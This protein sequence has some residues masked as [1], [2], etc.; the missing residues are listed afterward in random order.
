MIKFYAFFFE[1]AELLPNLLCTKTFLIL[2]L[3]KW[4][5]ILNPF[6]LICPTKHDLFV[7][8]KSKQIEVVGESTDH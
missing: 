3:F 7:D 6:L 5:T 1:F 2:C 8:D 4:E